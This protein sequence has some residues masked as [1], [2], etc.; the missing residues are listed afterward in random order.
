MQVKGHNGTVSFYGTFVTITRKGFLARA[1]VGK[2]EKRI[3]VGQITA[4]QFKPAGIVTNGFIQFTIGGGIERRSKFGSQTRD[5]VEDENSVVFHK[6]QQPAFEQ[7]RSAIE[8]S[9]AAPVRNGAPQ[10]DA[11][12]QLRR[13]AELRDAGLVSPEEFAA[14]KTRLLG[15]LSP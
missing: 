5:A 9:I 2:G 6:A 15:G 3:P 10:P 13:L 11:V 4:V 14:T 7:L 12:D 1:T 8:A